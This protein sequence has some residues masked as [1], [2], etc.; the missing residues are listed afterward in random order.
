MILNFN[1]RKLST[2][3]VVFCR[4]FFLI[5]RF[6][7]YFCVLLFLNSTLLK[8]LAFCIQR[9]RRTGKDC[10]KFETK[11]CFDLPTT[12]YAFGTCCFWDLFM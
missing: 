8:R 1:L 10:K 7:C 11:L 3:V 9:T 6:C 4:C 12:D 2:K 5:F